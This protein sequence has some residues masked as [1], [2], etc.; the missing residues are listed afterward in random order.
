MQF[1]GP[2]PAAV[3]IL[4]LS[5]VSAGAA[6]ADGGGVTTSTSAETSAAV[7]FLRNVAWAEVRSDR[8]AR[9]YWKV[10]R[11]L[12]VGRDRTG[13][14][15]TY[16]VFDLSRY[17]GQL[18]VDAQLVL[19]RTSARS[20]RRLG[21]SVHL[22][23]PVGQRTTWRSVPHHGSALSVSRLVQACDGEPGRVEWDVTEGLQ[24]RVDAGADRAVFLVRS[25]REQERAAYRTHDRRGG[26]Q[27]ESVGTP[28]APTGIE[29]E[30]TAVGC[31]PEQSPPV[32]WDF[33]LA[34]TLS[35]TQS[36]PE[37]GAFLAPVFRGRDLTTGAALPEVVELPRAQGAVRTAPWV[38]ESGHTYEWSVLSR[39]QWQ[40]PDGSPGLLDGPAAGPCYLTMQ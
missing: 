36:S 4:L 38:L 14:R 16:Y 1:A 40:Q 18:V 2:G 31:G 13:V 7:S 10:R 32:V 25:T 15:R 35:L 39:R 17:A 11:D 24:A 9:S 19:E 28:D 12:A 26:L 22:A 23:G 3:A 20:C 37:E 5:L 6:R 27:V 8:P 33:D 21:T 30:G 34:P 29:T